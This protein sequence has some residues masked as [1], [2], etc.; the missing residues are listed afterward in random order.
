MTE[1]IFEAVRKTGQRVLLS[2]GWGGMGAD[3][4]RV[5]NGI[6]MLG[7]VP[8]DWLL[9]HV[10]CV[11]HHGGAGIIAV[12][13]AAGRPTVVVPFFGDHPL[14]SAMVARAGAD[15]DPIPH[16]HLTAER[17]ADAIDFCPRP[18]SPEHAQELASKVAA[19]RGSDI[20]TQSFHQHLGHDQFRC[21]FAPSRPAA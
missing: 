13:I 4:L 2:Q 11:V 19:E 8:H 12:G 15:P 6:F 14:W 5:P 21:T 16:N 3:R 18:E 9:K 1:L 17:L 7:N 10:S 20:D